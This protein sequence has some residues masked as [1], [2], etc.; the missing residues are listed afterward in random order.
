[1]RCREGSGQ[2]DNQER[3]AAF[4]SLRHAVRDLACE[5]W[6]RCTA[7]L[8][9][10]S[11]VVG[12]EIGSRRSV[13]VTVI[14]HP[15]AAWTLQPFREVLAALLA[16]GSLTEMKHP[17]GVG[18]RPAAETIALFA[19]EPERVAQVWAPTED[20]PDDLVRIRQFRVVGHGNDPD[21]HRADIARRRRR[22]RRWKA[23]GAVIRGRVQPS[24]SPGD[25]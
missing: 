19:A 23:S 11:G 6:V 15:M 9:V 1:M 16:G 21:D 7:S 17:G 14:C 8:R 2:S 3:D 4:E 12:M 25:P 5:V 13:H 22:V 10:L 18:P 20:G 24:V